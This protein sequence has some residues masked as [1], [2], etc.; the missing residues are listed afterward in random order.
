MNLLSV[1]GPVPTRSFTSV[2]ATSF[3]AGYTLWSTIS[4]APVARMYGHVDCAVLRWNETLY[5]PLVVTLFRFEIRPQIPEGSWILLTR[6]KDHLT[7]VEV[8]GSPFENLTPFLSVHVHTVTDAFA[9]HPV[10]SDGAGIVLPA[11]RSRRC[12]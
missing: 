3:A 8:N 9:L 4:P 10:A 6:S 11:L 7:S 5:G 1:Y 12:W 2:F